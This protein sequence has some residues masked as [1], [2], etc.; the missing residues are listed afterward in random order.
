ML[1]FDMM[2]FFAVCS[3]YKNV[4]VSFFIPFVRYIEEKRQNVK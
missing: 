1:I 2:V 3:R 4:V